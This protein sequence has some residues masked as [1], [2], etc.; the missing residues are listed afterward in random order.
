MAFEAL[1][2]PDRDINGIDTIANTSHNTGSNQ[3]DAF[4]WRSLEYRAK[5]HDPASP[6]NTPFTAK[7]I[8][9]QECNNGTNE[10]TNV[11]DGGYDAFKPG[12]RVVE[13][14]SERWQT[15]DRA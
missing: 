14:S 10:T 9:W 15:N 1:S 4:P 12:T 3:L 5:N 2:L 7:A 6:L 8:G 11:V 13:I